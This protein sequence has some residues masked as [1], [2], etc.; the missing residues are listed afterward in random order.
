M[1]SQGE[2]NR[3]FIHE[4]YIALDQVLYKISCISHPKYPRTASLVAF[5]SPFRT[6]SIVSDQ[7]YTEVGLVL[8]P[9]YETVSEL[10]V[11]RDEVE[12]SGSCEHDP[13]Y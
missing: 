7:T 9:C 6:F 2:Y 11:S 1:D 12:A 4:P 10:D 3:A 13:S 8:S 5:A